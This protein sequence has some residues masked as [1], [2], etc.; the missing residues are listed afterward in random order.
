MIL[1]LSGCLA[2]TET[3]RIR[4][5]GRGSLLCKARIPPRVR[6][7]PEVNVRRRPERD[8]EEISEHLSR[9]DDYQP[10]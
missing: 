7:I 9:F 4:Y 10:E 1:L 6:M 3:S 8:A 2:G 5:S